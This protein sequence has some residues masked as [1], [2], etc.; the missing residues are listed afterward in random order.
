MI[1][2][3]VWRSSKFR[4][5]DSIEARLVYLYLHT[6]AHGNSAGCFHISPALIAAE[7]KVSD[8][9]AA[10]A[11]L[12]RVGLIRRDPSED[13]VQIVAF[14]TF[15]MPSSR[16]QLAGPLAILEAIPRGPVL[17]ALRA[18]LAV[19]LYTR[20]QEWEPTVEARGVFLNEAAKLIKAG[21][22]TAIETG[23]VEVEDDILIALSEALLIDLSNGLSIQKKR[24]RNGKD[25]DH[26]KDHGEDQDHG[27]D[28]GEGVQGERF[29]KK[30]PED[31]QATIDALGAKARGRA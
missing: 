22:G 15:N 27:E 19:A 23:S 12:E 9:E 20:A 14:F 25:H 18:E 21:G 3:R 17:N 24:K 5:L 4:A 13:L 30:S 6:S 1:G 28:H 16:K 26:G 10:L 11:E 2:S 7:S 31:I 8:V 29:K